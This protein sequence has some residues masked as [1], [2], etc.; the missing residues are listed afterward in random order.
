[1]DTLNI[2]RLLPEERYELL[3]LVRNP[4]PADGAFLDPPEVTLFPE[5]PLRRELENFINALLSRR[6]GAKG[7][8]L[9]GDYGTGKTHYL[10]Y[11]RYYMRAKFPEVATF[12]VEHPGYGFHDFAGSVI[13]TIGLGNIVRK[14][15]SLIREQLLMRTRNRDLDW[16]YDIFPAERGKFPVFSE[17]VREH[18]MEDY[19]VF[20]DRA[21]KQKSDANIIIAL[22]SEI[23]EQSLDGIGASVARRLARVLTEA[24]YKSYFDWEDL[25]PTKRKEIG[26]YE[27]LNSILRL[28]RKVDEYRCILILVD[29]FEEIPSSGRFS[30]KE[31][32]DYE[33]TMRRLLDLV[34]ALPVGMVIAMT[35][36]AWELTQDYCKP[37][38]SRLMR[39]IW[40]QPLTEEGARRLLI[41]YLNAARKKQQD[42]I[43]PLPDTLWELL[44]DIVRDNPRNLLNFCHNVTED[45]AAKRMET[46]S[47][48]LIR[49]Y[50]NLWRVEFRQMER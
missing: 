12:Y 4:F 6:R 33:Y 47:E 1:M 25:S 9:I 40:I 27:F 23:L 22:F 43:V 8:A 28:I 34:S 42:A 50:A 18:L 45:A 21:R 3:G 7:R 41:A 20:L 44:P 24:H 49:E 48:G 35:S 14:Q 29:E 16:Y 13:R 11:I 38:A 26:D 17:A 31:A 39:P 15:W 46:I 36:P 37:L 32:T 5:E 30:V 2:N 19:R 10:K